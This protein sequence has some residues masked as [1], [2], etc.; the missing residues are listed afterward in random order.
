[1]TRF[2]R[3]RAKTARAR[4]LRRAMTDAEKRLWWRLRGDQLG[5][6]FRR[7]HPIGR[8]VVDFY[9]ASIGLAIEL[10]GGQHGTETGVAA[11]WRRT[12]FLATR[13]LKVARFW[14]HEVMNNIE[15]VLETIWNLALSLREAGP[16]TPTP[17]LP[18]GGGGSEV[19]AASAAAALPPP[20]RGR[21]ALQGPGGGRALKGPGGGL[22]GAEG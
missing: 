9:A 19:G 7:Q 11:D 5:L 16:G 14:N 4:H 15:G 6:S 1:M 13:G 10:D 20:A 22:M 8:Y 12:A 18:L 2:D 3:T 21:S 17:T